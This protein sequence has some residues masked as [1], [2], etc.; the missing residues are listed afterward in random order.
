VRARGRDPARRL[1]RCALAAGAVTLVPW[2]VAPRC[3][4]LWAL[5]VGHGTSVVGHGPGLPLVVFDAGTTTRHGLERHA[6]RPLLSRLDASG[7]LLV[8]SHL[9]RDH[10][11]ALPWLA[12]R[13]LFARTAG[14]WPDDLDHEVP[15]LDVEHTP[16]ALACP[17]PLGERVAW[18]VLRGAGG[19]D[20]EG[21]R[22]LELEHRGA[23]V[24][25]CGDATGRGLLA[26]A[27]A[28]LVPRGVALLLLAHHGRHGSG[29][30]ALL[31]AAA[32][33]LV[34]V[35]SETHAPLVDEL[36][37]RGLEWRGTFV[38]GPL[39]PWRGPGAPRPPP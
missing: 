30:G 26:L 39:G 3:L 34:W 18:R 20:N 13:G 8:T 16:G 1:E 4:E 15:H 23:R 6:L 22:N 21:S 38:E 31:A 5:D 19:D 28:D 36:E 35:S 11:S 10:G 14:A 32:P 24:L 2:T 25:L 9:D 29:S 17:A 12:R 7:G 27:S 33:G 37:R